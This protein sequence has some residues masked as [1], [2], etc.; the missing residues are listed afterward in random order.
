MNYSSKQYGLLSIGLIGFTVVAMVAVALT[1]ENP[2]VQVLC[3]VI[4]LF[5]LGVG[6]VFMSLSVSVSDSSVGLSFGIGLI[7]REIPLERIEAAEPVRNPWWYGF[8]IRRTPR[9]WMWNVQGLS[10]VELTYTDGGR[11]RI[12]TSDPEGLTQ[13]IDAARMPQ[14]PA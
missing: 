3:G 10:A 9:G 5:F 11:F 14:P 4:A 13:A 7:R 1:T 2:D 6:L 8:G 12:G